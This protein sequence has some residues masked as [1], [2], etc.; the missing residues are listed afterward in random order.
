MANKG[1]ELTA[2]SVRSCLAPASS[3]SSRLALGL[4]VQGDKREG[5][6]PSRGVWASRGPGSGPF[7]G[8]SE[9]LWLPSSLTSTHG[10]AIGAEIFHHMLRPNVYRTDV[11]LTALTSHWSGQATAHAFG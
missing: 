6:K 5:G 1:V 3:R 7:P 10:A 11:V 2:Y 9:F 8:V 4:S